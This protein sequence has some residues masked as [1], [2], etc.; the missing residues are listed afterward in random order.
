MDILY[1]MLSRQGRDKTER[2]SVATSSR[3]A[4]GEGFGRITQDTSSFPKVG[5][6]PG[7]R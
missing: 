4:K 3:R 7:S 6:E 2:G 5:R 1:R